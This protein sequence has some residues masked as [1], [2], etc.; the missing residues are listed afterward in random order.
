MVFL[1]LLHTAIAQLKSVPVND[2]G[3]DGVDWNWIGL[4]SGLQY[5]MQSNY[6][7]ALDMDWIL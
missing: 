1:T 4:K 3:D 7:I 5:P 6:W 2:F